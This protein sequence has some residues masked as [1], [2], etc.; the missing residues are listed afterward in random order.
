M[1]VLSSGV[2]L[3]RSTLPWLAGHSRSSI[4]PM[5]EEKVIL[6]VPL[7]GAALIPTAFR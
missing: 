4:S 6:V 7:G 3:L 1:D 5:S 2:G